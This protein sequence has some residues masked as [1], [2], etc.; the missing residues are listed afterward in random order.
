MT[1]V[2]FRLQISRCSPVISPTPF[3]FHQVSCEDGITWWV[4]DKCPSLSKP[5][6]P[7]RHL[8]ECMHVRQGDRHRGAAGTLL[9]HI[10][11][12]YDALPPYI[13]LLKENP[14]TV[15]KG[16][17]ILNLKLHLAGMNRTTGFLN[18]ADFPA[19]VIPFEKPTLSQ[20]ATKKFA[21]KWLTK[22][23]GIKPYCA[24]YQTYTCEDVCRN[25][26]VNHGSRLLVS[27]ARIQ[28]LPHSEYKRLLNLTKITG[29]YNPKHVKKPADPYAFE[30][31]W[32]F[33]FSCYNTLKMN[34]KNSFSGDNSFL[35]GTMPIMQCYDEQ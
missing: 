27:A 19:S 28:S 24:L 31:R 11:N 8:L 5:Y 32:G 35:P 6:Q 3:N 4:Y 25:A 17:A 29:L 13:A 30:G 2:L 15:Y 16:D 20:R 21:F 10:V 1:R 7:P 23:G 18:L 33:L 34:L 9:N 26:I 22:V 12:Y 14:A